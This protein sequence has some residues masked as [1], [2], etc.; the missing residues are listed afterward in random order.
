MKKYQDMKNVFCYCAFLT[1]SVIS[2]SCNSG[3]PDSSKDAKDSNAVKMDS[4]GTTDHATPSVPASVSKDDAAFA[5]EA[6]GGGMEEVQLG[7]LA[8][9]KGSGQDVKDFG[10][11]MVKDH[12]MGGDKLKAIAGGKNLTLP[13]SLSAD[14]QK[15]MADLQSKN[16]T[17]FD[18]AYINMM[19]D[20]HKKDIK[21]FENEAK[22]GSDADIRGFADSNLHML[23]MHLDA[24]EKCHKMEKKM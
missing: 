11:M 18:K 22:N 1:L 12:S 20:D 9:Q 7:K 21:L 3:Q 17:D 8:V 13:D 6:A 5:V 16:G 10:A 4:S 2:F 14:A 15:E 19:V 24:A 23:H